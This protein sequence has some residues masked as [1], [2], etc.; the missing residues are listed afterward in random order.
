M[1]ILI[2]LIIVEELL[3]L[4]QIHSTAYDGTYYMYTES[5]T[6]N[7]PNKEAIMYVPCVDP[8]Q[9]TQLSLFLGT[10]CMVQQWEH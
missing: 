3:L 7:Y 9:W 4:I 2:G 8:T 1:T 5:S 6:P 10:I